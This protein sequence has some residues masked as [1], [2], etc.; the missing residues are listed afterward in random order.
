[1]QNTRQTEAG[2]KTRFSSEDITIT[3]DLDTIK[4]SL[5]QSIWWSLTGSNR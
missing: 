5:D 2:R 1:M 3:A 4:I